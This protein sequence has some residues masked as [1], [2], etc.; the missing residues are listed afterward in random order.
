MHDV[1]S[2]APVG[3]ESEDARLASLGYKPQLNRVLGPVRELLGRVHL[4]LAHGG[5][6]LAVRRLGVAAAGPGLPLAHL[7]SP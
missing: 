4:P 7:G 6:L 3:T 2:P 5:H 1:A